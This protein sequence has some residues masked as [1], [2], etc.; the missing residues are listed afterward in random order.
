MLITKENE[1][2]FKIH[3]ILLD[4]GS[5]VIQLSIEH[6]IKENEPIS[7]FLR[8]QHNNMNRP[9]LRDL[10]RTLDD[11]LRNNSNEYPD[12]LK[13]FDISSKITIAQNL[14]N[15]LSP[16]A[17]EI[18][19]DN[20][21]FDKCLNN[22]RVIRNKFYGHL[23]KYE[24][25]EIEYNEILEYLK[26]LI[27]ELVHSFDPN[28]TSAYEQRIIQ[29][30]N[31]NIIPADEFDEFKIDIE[32]LKSQIQ[33]LNENQCLL[34]KKLEEIEERINTNN[35]E[36]GFTS[37][38]YV[39]DTRCFIRRD[40]DEEILEKLI[41]KEDTDIIVLTG[42]GGI[43]K[44]I[45]ASYLANRLF[46]KF[47]YKFKWLDCNSDL[48]EKYKLILKKE[49]N[50]IENNKD[51]IISVLCNK[52]NDE[53]SNILFVFDNILNIEEKKDYIL[54]L[55]SKVKIIIT[56]RNQE[57]KIS[58][59]NRKSKK[60]VLNVWNKLQAKYYLI[61]IEE[62]RNLSLSDEKLNEILNDLMPNDII[63]PLKLDIA[64]KLV[65][66]NET[67]RLDKIINL[68]K[69]EPTDQVYIQ[70]VIESFKDNKLTENILRYFSLLNT[71]FVEKELIENIIEFKD[72]SLLEL[73]KKQSLI[74]G[75]RK[76]DVYG[77]RI[78][79]F[80]VETIHERTKKDEIIVA[81]EH[82]IQKMIGLI[83]LKFDQNI[84]NKENENL[85]T[86]L[87]SLLKYYMSNKEK[88]KKIHYNI[89][90]LFMKIS[91]KMNDLYDN[92]FENQLKYSKESMEI[93]KI[94]HM[95]Q[96]YNLDLAMIY[97][98][99]GKAYKKTGDYEISLNYLFKSLNIHEKLKEDQPFHSDLATI[100]FSIAILYKYLGDYENHLGYLLK[101]LKINKDL[102]NNFLDQALYFSAVALAHECIGDNNGNLEYLLKSLEIYEKSHLHQNHLNL[103]KVY[104]KVAMAY[105]KNGNY[106]KCR[107]Y[108]YKSLEIGELIFKSNPNHPYMAKCYNCIALAYISNGNIEM[109]LEYSLK[110]LEIHEKTYKDHPSLDNIYNHASLAYSKCG[111][112]KKQLEY[113]LKSL[114]IF[115]KKNRPYNKKR[116]ENA[117][118]NV[119]LAYD[120]NKNYEKQLEYSL[121]SL[122]IGEL[123]FNN[124]PDHLDKADI[125]DNVSMSYKNNGNDEK[126][127]EFMLK[128]LEIREKIHKTQ[129]NQTELATN[130]N[131]VSFKIKDNIC[132]EYTLES[133]ILGEK[134][135]NHK[136]NN[137]KIAKIYNNVS[138][139]YQNNRNYKKFLEFSIKSLEITEKFLKNQ[140][141]HSELE[142]NI[143]RNVSEAYRLNGNF[144]KSLEYSKK[145]LEIGTKLYKENH[146]DLAN[147]YE[148]VA[149]AHMSKGENENNLIYLLKSVE[150]REKIYQ[151]Q[152]NH[153]DLA[154]SYNNIALAYNYIGNYENL[155]KYSLKSL[156][157]FE[158]LY[159]DQ[160]F[161]PD[162]ETVY[163]T[164]SLAYMN[165]KNHEKHLKYSFKSSV[166]Q[167]K[168]YE[169]QPD[170]SLLLKLV[171]SYENVS[172][173]YRNNGKYEK[174]L[175]FLLKSL[176]SA[177][178]IY[179]DNPYNINLATIYYNVSMA[180]KDN[181]NNT[182]FLEYSLISFDVSK[183]IYKGQNNHPNLIKAYDLYKMA[184]SYNNNAS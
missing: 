149:T 179:K 95:N 68:L 89:A 120:N 126:Y 163:Y 37:D 130:Y 91:T 181:K 119:S 50:Q 164:V 175:E 152:P 158:K 33:F 128:S 42:I 112:Y 31:I 41:D 137:T 60:F 70:L 132:H 15:S 160:P 135:T 125:Y 14:L 58:N 172:L 94:V 182:K 171:R 32:N 176:E 76:N 170:N 115:E 110:S 86:H 114:E 166:I 106:E 9:F 147:I 22:L 73:L 102:N 153:P 43:G 18:E 3:K 67:E 77:Y 13:I 23:K 17:N 28:A 59:V 117:Y 39:P 178:I 64:V 111:D 78:H 162:L 19:M 156:D 4:I 47:N 2:A 46:N 61:E 80:V 29:I 45:L 34:N 184:Y 52:L 79:D 12:N 96:P 56:T 72:I 174:Q 143:F 123:I 180:Y 127:L 30:Q 75:L 25:I 27:K 66:D 98:D 140:T 51:Y 105:L 109:Y 131:N 133:P 88:T 116:L 74:I 36:I 38:N 92:Y 159:K 103:L 90:H 69:T 54:K 104:N 81:Y 21:N 167:K 173:A 118:M 122:E 165:D 48:N 142:E 161:H 139:V 101:L 55:P 136:T 169:D 146:P 63:S 108:S 24:I 155:L 6:K 84:Y 11:F 129:N 20:L 150:I 65:V 53:K 121:K 62:I 141:D 124:Q 87:D 44:T 154:K 7:D 148:N 145:S 16:R 168:L 35:K 10:K 5:E 1:H 40:Q 157:I 49:F 177:K 113:S 71:E 85:F 100:H 83:D 8:R 107:E 134:I 97:Y 82:I 183:E 144:E 151:N 99:V 57:L 138:K 26:I 93:F